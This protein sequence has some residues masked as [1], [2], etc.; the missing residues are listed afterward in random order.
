MVPH[1]WKFTNVNF[2][3]MK[4][5]NTNTRGWI[6]GPHIRRDIDMFVNPNVRILPPIDRTIPSSRSGR[7]TRVYVAQDWNRIMVSA[8][9]FQELQD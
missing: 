9:E 6:F 8:R 1:N 3:N 4:M 2:A 5:I 7:Q